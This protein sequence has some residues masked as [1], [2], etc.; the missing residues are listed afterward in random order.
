M[1]LSGGSIFHRLLVRY[2]TITDVVIEKF[3]LWGAQREH[4]RICVGS[5]PDA[6]AR[7]TH[8]APAEE[9]GDAI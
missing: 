7:R 2:Q 8:I 4:T 3:L 6:L 5:R 9:T 1:A